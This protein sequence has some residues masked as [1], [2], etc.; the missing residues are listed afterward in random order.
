MDRSPFRSG[1]GAGRLTRG[2]RRVAL[3]AALALVAVVAA[4]GLAV[5]GGVGAQDATPGPDADAPATISISGQGRV[6]IEPDT[7]SV[8]A[9]I[10]ILR[11]TLAEAQAEATTQM[12]AIIY[13][14]KAA[15]IEERDIKTVNYS[16]NIVRDYDQNGNPAEIQGYQVS[17]QV[18]VVIRDTDAL[19]EI[20]D[21]V[22]A[23]GANN[24]YGISFYVEDT[25][26]AASQAR[27]QA[28]EAVSYTHLTLPTICS[29]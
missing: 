4:A 1:R 17:N 20:L 15:G 23:E 8:V 9:G 19:G 11:P 26:A 18:A 21:A 2:P 13:A 29:V 22:V 10:D 3:T 25:E 27:R 14:V 12:T 7:A 28:V 5:P 6:T 24:I 16:V